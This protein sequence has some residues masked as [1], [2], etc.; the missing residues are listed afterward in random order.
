[1]AKNQFGSAARFGIATSGA[2]RLAMRL[3]NLIIREPLG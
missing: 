1:M 3:A 2:A